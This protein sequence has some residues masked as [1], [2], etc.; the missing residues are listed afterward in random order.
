MVL[1]GDLAESQVRNKQED[2]I[3]FFSNSILLK[4]VV[5]LMASSD[6]DLQEKVFLSLSTWG[7]M[8]MNNDEEFYTKLT[9]KNTVACGSRKLHKIFYR[10]WHAMKYIV[11]GQ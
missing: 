10:A 7:I 1:V 4:S 11:Y 2:V 8:I 5:D 9:R 6:L 3:P